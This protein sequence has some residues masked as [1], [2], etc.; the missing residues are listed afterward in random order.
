MRGTLPLLVCTLLLTACG[1]DPQELAERSSADS[2]RA[3]VAVEL[4]QAS[5]RDREQAS[6]E[7][8]RAERDAEAAAARRCEAVATLPASITEIVRDPKEYAAADPCGTKLIDEVVA[9]FVRTNDKAY[10][11]ALDALSLGGDSKTNEALGDAVL[12]LFRARPVELI[13]HLY[14]LQGDPASTDVDAL[15]VSVVQLGDDD[16]LDGE[17]RAI[18]RRLDRGVDLSTD[19]KR[20]LARLES[21]FWG[22]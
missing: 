16:E 13:R 21:Q 14:D 19:Q 3:A 5:L 11:E 17:V 6:V 1:S 22:T 7:Q 15:L 20:Y 8:E 9:R 10:L 12:D 4:R 2:L 18:L